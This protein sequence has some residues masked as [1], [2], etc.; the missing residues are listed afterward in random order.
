MG[1]A[2]DTP[3]AIVREFRDVFA[4][5]DSELGAT[6]HQ[7]Q[8]LETVIKLHRKHRVDVKNEVQDMLQRGIINHQHSVQCNNWV[9]RLSFCVDYRVTRKDA[10]RSTLDALR[11]SKWF[12]NFG[13]AMQVGRMDIQ[14]Q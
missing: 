11:G 7:N 9:Q 6:N 2:K 3:G 4:V 5:R 14:L 10:T 12:P 13:R 8:A 1:S